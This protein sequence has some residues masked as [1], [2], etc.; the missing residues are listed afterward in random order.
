MKRFH[1][2][3]PARNALHRSDETRNNKANPLSA[4][5]IS[6]EAYIEAERTSPKQA[7]NRARIRS[8]LSGRSRSRAGDLL[9]V[10]FTERNL[11]AAEQLLYR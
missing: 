5:R 8:W 1:A 3:V 9:P 7:G 6:R 4:T 2:R 11:S 10:G